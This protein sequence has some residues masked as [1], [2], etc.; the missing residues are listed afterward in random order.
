MCCGTAHTGHPKVLVGSVKGQG[1]VHQAPLQTLPNP[2]EGQE[3]FWGRGGGWC[4]VQYIKQ[5][6][7]V[8]WRELDASSQNTQRTHKHARRESVPRTVGAEGQY[9]RATV[10]G[11]RIRT[12]TRTLQRER[13]R[14]GKEREGERLKNRWLRNQQEAA[15]AG[16]NGETDDREKRQ[17]PE[18]VCSEGG[19]GGGRGGGRAA[20]ARLNQRLL[21]VNQQCYT[22]HHDTTTT[23]TAATV[24]CLNQPLQTHTAAHNPLLAAPP[25]LLLL[26]PKRASA[27]GA[28][29]ARSIMHRHR[30]QTQP[31]RGGRPKEKALT[32]QRWRPAP[33]RPWALLSSRCWAAGR[34]GPGGSPR[35]ATRASGCPPPP[36]AA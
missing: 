22:L 28:V 29:I 1:A 9:L 24:P 27:D 10:Q 12:R 18:R 14:R 31:R 34:T 4:C 30:A 35:P 3:F 13:E 32:S 17:T 25:L 16:E 6:F 21:F 26:L 11:I 5:V 20:H 33:A 23:T 7:A 8:R 36:R 19:R 15:A 2:G